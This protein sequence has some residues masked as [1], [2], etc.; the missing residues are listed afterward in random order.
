MLLTKKQVTKIIEETIQHRIKEHG[1]IGEFADD[2][3]S[4]DDESRAVDSHASIADAISIAVFDALEEMGAGEKEAI[5]S[6]QGATGED[7]MLAAEKGIDDYLRKLDLMGGMPKP[8]Q[9]REGIISTLM[10][11]GLTWWIG[12]KLFGSRFKELYDEDPE[13]REAADEITSG[14][15]KLKQKH[16]GIDKAKEEF[17]ELS[18]EVSDVGSS[19]INRLKDWWGK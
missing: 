4:P 15:E 3:V 14:W 8:T 19:A 12:R 7:L 6:L 17:G 10:G 2:E 1:D 13:V 9:L 11:L 18:D 16:P 5:A